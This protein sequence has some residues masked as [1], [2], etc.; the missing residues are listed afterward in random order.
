M[1]TKIMKK[2]KRGFYRSIAALHDRPLEPPTNEEEQLAGELRATFHTLASEQI[3]NCSPS[4]KEWFTNVNRLKELVLNHNPREF[5]RWDIILR[6]MSVAYAS[7]ITPE[8]K[9]LKSRSD[10]ESRWRKAIKECPVGHPIPHWRHPR[11]SGNLIHHAY[12]LVQFEEKT[13]MR[14]N[15]MNC[16]FEFGGGYGS[17]CRLVHNLGFQG[18]Y[19]LFD[20]PAFSALQKFFL[21]SIYIAV[22]TVDSFKKAEKGVVCIS[23]IEQLREILS[24][25]TEAGNSMFIATWSISETPL[26]LRA[27]IFPLI[28]SFKA[29]LIG[30]QNQFREVNNID[31]FKNWTVAQGDIEWYDWKIEHIPN[32]NRYLVGKRKTN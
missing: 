10:W 27:L 4:E 2:L 16:I 32:H 15:N 7:Y 11:S 30:Y 28:S 25:H 19:V 1:F 17:M 6:T 24:N 20:L 13:T 12:H 5:L 9:Y 23:D 8:L 3:T 31:F 29:F 21:K 18:K 22:H 14:V 26:K